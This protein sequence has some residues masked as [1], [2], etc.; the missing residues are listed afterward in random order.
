MEDGMDSP[1][2][3]YPRRLALAVPSW[4]RFLEVRGRFVLGED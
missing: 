3:L 2:L 4:S 1:L